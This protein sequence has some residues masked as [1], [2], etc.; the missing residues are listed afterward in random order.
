MCGNGERRE[1]DENVE[2]KI[3]ERDGLLVEGTWSGWYFD[4]AKLKTL[5]DEGNYYYQLE[6]P[7]LFL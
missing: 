2:I 3:V 7:Q 4:S 6:T 5:R 1:E